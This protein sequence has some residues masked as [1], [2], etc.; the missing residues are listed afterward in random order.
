M[1]VI[2]LAFLDNIPVSMFVLELASNGDPIYVAFNK[3]ANDVSKFQPSDYVG[4]TAAQLFYGDYGERAY[5]YHLEAFRTAKTNVYELTLPLNGKLQ[6]VRTHLVP[7]VDA[8]GQV[9]RIL[10]TSIDIT[11]ERELKRMREQTQ[12]I[13]KELQEFI[14]L[15]AHDLRSPM[16]QVIALADMLRDDFEDLGDGKLDVI[17]MLERVS[18]E[19]LSMVKRVLQ[20]AEISGIEESIESMK[21]RDVCNGLLTM[22]D[23]TKTHRSRIADCSIYGDRVLI[24]TILRNLVDNC[25]KHN[26]GACVS[27]DVDAK[28]TVQGFFL[29]TVTDNGKGM[30]EP[31]K[32]FEN[33]ETD[34][35]QSGF[36]LLAIRKLVKVRGG[37]I[38]AEHA[39]TGTGLSVSVILPGTVN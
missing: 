6:Q 9:V 38:S 1:D 19:S 35:S 36:G 28:S 5:Q 33:T 10:G 29:L 22:L 8:E 11:A 31:G 25:F 17:D 7:T 26:A 21:L 34:R 2:D 20:H 27:I 12:G 14:Y 37:D 30:S 23:P 32:L 18:I 3:T 4:R 15:A 24:Q 39:A 13:G 16:R